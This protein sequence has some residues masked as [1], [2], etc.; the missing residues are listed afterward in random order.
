MSTHARSPHVAVVL[1]GCGRG[2]GSEIHEAVSCLIH[3]SRLGARYAC[4]APDAPQADVVN[5][6]TGKPV[7]GEKRNQLVEAARIARGEIVPLA[8]LDVD[9]F[10]AVVFPGGF[11]AAKNLCTFARDGENCTVI[12]DVERVVK[13]FQGAGKPIGMCC[14]APVIAA[15]VLGKAAGGPGCTVTIGDDAGTAAAISRMGA[16]NVVK[17]VTDA[18]VDERN[19][20]ATSPAYMYGQASP[21]QVYEGIGKMIEGVLKLARSEASVPR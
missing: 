10:D 20:L 2:D 4:F 9:G 18:L 16:A 3:L 19:R 17:K 1:S 5:H 13:E 6:T 12:P 15:R 21:H 8:K 11:G 14:I 7:P